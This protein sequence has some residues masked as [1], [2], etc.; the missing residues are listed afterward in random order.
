[1]VKALPV[2]RWLTQRLAAIMRPSAPGEKRRRKGRTTMKALRRRGSRD[3]RHESF[4]D[5]K[6]QDERDVLVK[7][8]RRGA[9]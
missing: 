5:A 1:M 2:F 4:D 7:M 3:I 8:E 9:C 6:L